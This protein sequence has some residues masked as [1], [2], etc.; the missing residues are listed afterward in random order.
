VGFR[1]YKQATP[2]GFEGNSIGHHNVKPASTCI[3]FAQRNRSKLW[4]MTRL[5]TLGR[6]IHAPAL[7]AG[8]F[9]LAKDAWEPNDNS[10][11]ILH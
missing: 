8:R 11:I 6:V 9:H 1:C 2:L 3:I 10:G 7:V 5:S 4:V